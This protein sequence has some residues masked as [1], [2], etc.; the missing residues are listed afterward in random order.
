M[1]C[2]LF[3]E[4]DHIRKETKIC[5]GNMKNMMPKFKPKM[6]I[7]GI[8]HQILCNKSKK[9]ILL[10][11]WWDHYLLEGH[12]SSIEGIYMFELR[13]DQLWCSYSN[14]SNAFYLKSNP[15]KICLFVFMNQIV[16]KQV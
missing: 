12:F 10:F 13:L 16:K 5:Q 6:C 8:S 4:N 9:Q 3:H 15:K 14:D 11:A 1:L 2:E 7:A